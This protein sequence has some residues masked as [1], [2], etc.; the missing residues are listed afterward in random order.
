MF[1][2][3]NKY[4]NILLNSK[5]FILIIYTNNINCRRYPTL[6]Q[7]NFRRIKCSRSKYSKHH[8]QNHQ[9]LQ[10]NICHQIKFFGIVLC[11]LFSKTAH[12][13]RTFSCIKISYNYSIHNPITFNTLI[14]S[15][16]VYFVYFT[17][18]EISNPFPEADNIYQLLFDTLPFRSLVIVL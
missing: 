7:K 6:L 10:N 13:N 16:S 9:T 18:P 17:R 11:P 8:N 3:L 2:N 1:F 14:I 5:L 4:M 15:S 12:K